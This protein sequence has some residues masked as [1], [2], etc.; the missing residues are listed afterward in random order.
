MPF[1]QFGHDASAPFT[2]IGSA[3]FAGATNNPNASPIAANH[4]TVVSFVCLFVR[5]THLD[6]S[7]VR[8][9]L[10]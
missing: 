8:A 9:A 5:V 2:G 1:G 7:L 10:A 6:S 4:L 3:A